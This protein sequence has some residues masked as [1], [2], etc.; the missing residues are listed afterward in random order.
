M[1]G[2]SKAA[3]ERFTQGLAQEVYAEGVT[4]VGVSRGIGVG[5]EGTVHFGIN[6]QPRRS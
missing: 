3:L 1:C 6:K 5:T 2:A 4:V